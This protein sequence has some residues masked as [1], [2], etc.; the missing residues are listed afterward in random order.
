MKKKVL[1]KL[2][3]S[4]ITASLLL[5]GCGQE[6]ENQ[7]NDIQS[8]EVVQEIADNE[9]RG[10]LFSGTIFDNLVMGETTKADVEKLL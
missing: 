10:K 6:S 5:S 4:L 2:F 8:S 3:L 1:S 9:E 7:E